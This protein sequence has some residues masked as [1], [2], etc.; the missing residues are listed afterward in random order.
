MKT[1]NIQFI[2]LVLAILA[3]ASCKKFLSVTPD[4]KVLESQAYQN[5]SGIN[6]VL[7]GLYL[8]LAKDALYGDNL[9]LSTMEILG[10]NYSVPGTHSYYSTLSFAQNQ[11]KTKFNTIWTSA[12]KNILSTNTFIENLD[13]YGTGV[14]TAN[15]MSIYKGEAIAMRAMMHFDLLRIFGPVYSNGD[16]TLNAIPYYNKST[17]SAN[18]ILPANKVMELV[19][20]DLKTA[21][22]MLAVDPIIASGVMP[23]FQNDG[24]D[25]LR[26]RNYRLNYY[27]VKA[28]EARVFLYRTDKVSA[29]AASKLVI[30]KKNYFP[31][32]S[33]D[34]I[35]RSTSPDRIFTTEM[36][37][38]I[39]CSQL[40]TKQNA[41]FSDALADNVIL[42]PNLTR[43]QNLYNDNINDFRYKL[44]WLNSGVKPYYSFN[45]YADVTNKSMPFRFTVPLLKLSEV[46]YIAA[47]CEP[48][49]AT[50]LEYLNTVR[51]NRGLQSLSATANLP[52][53]LTLEYQREFIGEGQIFF[54]YKRKNLNAIPNGSAATGNIAMTKANYIAPLPLSETDFYPTN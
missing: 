30:Q 53:E 16:S 13:K 26:N 34:S 44:N 51:N 22:S 4:D 19:I 39:Q 31:W 41:Y 1:K 10:Q 6:G 42:A 15:E 54:Y 3:L 12:Y 5:K 37:S 11:S 18:A 47:E 52:N 36:I 27:A 45:K 46:Y 50:A 23:T 25:F 2:A 7:N 28:L 33:A 24:K 20:A 49:N 9:T 21:E 14:L 35:N 17:Q 43:L 8:N 48:N 38:G 32:V 29:L 40:Y